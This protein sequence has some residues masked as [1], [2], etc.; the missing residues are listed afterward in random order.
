[1]SDHTHPLRCSKLLT[2]F[3]PRA[4]PKQ[5]ETIFAEEQLDL[6]AKLPVNVM[7]PSPEECS[8]LL[9]GPKISVV[10]DGNVV[11]RKNIPQAALMASSTK[12]LDLMQIK[13]S[14]TQYRVIGNVI[15]PTK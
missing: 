13:E 1:M 5:W 7:A 4:I 14:V 8:S 10:A 12:L 15:S 6:A 11:I 3:G 2:L 9:S